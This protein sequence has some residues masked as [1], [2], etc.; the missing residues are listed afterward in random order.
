MSL[1]IRNIIP[2]TAPD[3]AAPS[4]PTGD[5]TGAVLPQTSDSLE[6]RAWTASLAVLSSDDEYLKAAPDILKLPFSKVTLSGA[7]RMPSTPSAERQGAAH[8]RTIIVNNRF[9]ITGRL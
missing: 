2:L 5:D 4:S 8:R 7:G 9:F 3:A 1:S 6:A